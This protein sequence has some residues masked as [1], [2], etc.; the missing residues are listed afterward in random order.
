MA[1]QSDIGSM[2]SQVKVR[3]PWG[4]VGKKTSSIWLNYKKSIENPLLL[5]PFGPFGDDFPYEASFQ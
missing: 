4:K 1:W 3:Y 5:K 2:G